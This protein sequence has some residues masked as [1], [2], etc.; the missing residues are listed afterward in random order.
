[1]MHPLE[2]LRATF[3]QNANAIDQGIVAGKKSG[4]QLLVV[5]GEVQHRD[6]PD[7]AQRQKKFGFL[8]TAAADGD[9]IA[10]RGKPLNNVAADEARPAQ[11][12]GPAISHG[13]SRCAPTAP[14]PGAGLV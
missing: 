3:L 7:I 4:Q 5:N 8:G 11:H 12:R 13:S 10:P 6:L 14:C 2:A 9:H 1:M